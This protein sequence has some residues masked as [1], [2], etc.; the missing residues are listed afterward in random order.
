MWFP[1]I[2]N[3]TKAFFDNP[4]AFVIRKP[5]ETVI[6]SLALTILASV[7]MAYSTIIGVALYLTS[8]GIDLAVLNNLNT[9]M[10]ALS[11]KVHNF[12]ARNHPNPDVRAA[13]RLQEL[14]ESAHTWPNRVWHFG[15]DAAQGV[16]GFFSGLAT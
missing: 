11:A 4:D 14:E 13:H 15:R 1:S 8:F 12:I 10:H 3:D 2:Y 6:Y 9:F 16:R 5:V 7:A